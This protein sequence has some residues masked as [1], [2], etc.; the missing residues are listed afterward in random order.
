MEPAY[1]QAG[2][3]S[4]LLDGLD[5]R[6]RSVEQEGVIIGHKVVGDAHYLPE[7][8]ARWVSDANVVADGFAHLELA[9]GADEERG[10]DDA[11]R[12]LPIVLHHLP[13]HQQIVE[14]VRAAELD[15]SVYGDGVV[16]LHQRIQKLC[17]GYWVVRG[18]AFAEVVPLQYT[19]YR[20]RPGQPY[21]VS[22][23]E[24]REPLGVVADL[25]P[26]AIEDHV[27]LLEVGT[28]VLLYLFWREDRTR[29]RTPGRVA[30]ARSIVPYNKHRGV[31]EVLK[32]AKLL[33]HHGETE[34]DVRGRRVD[35]QFYP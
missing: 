20:R 23:G 3:L 15:V 30:H 16:S 32:G 29:L 8:L 31:P 33:E 25:G 6:H 10:R 2:K 17:Q 35:S 7:H 1:Q 27:G 14:L 4:F 19:R 12:P 26:F 28:R 24:R 13:A 18:V 34:V 5:L 21:Q 22:Q 11:L 9:V